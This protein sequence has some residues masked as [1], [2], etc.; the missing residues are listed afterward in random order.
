MAGQEVVLKE[1]VTKTKVEGFLQI[2]GSILVK[3]FHDIGSIN[4]SYGSSIAFS[5]LRLFEP[6]NVESCTDGIRVEM[7]EDGDSN[8]THSAFL[9][10]DE[11]GDLVNG[12]RYMADL[13]GQSHGYR[14]D[15]TEVIFSTR[16]DLKVGFY[17][18]DGKVQ[19]FVKLDYGT[20][21]CA[22]A[23]FT[24]IGELLTSGQAYLRNTPITFA[25]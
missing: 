15:Y 6:T 2:K 16:G 3:I 8:Q 9:D 13:A 4:A 18:S 25:Q 5:T 22:P 7:K 17:V 21:Y 20:V 23:M 24:R 14:G 19:A 1:H 12:I 11:V 10:M